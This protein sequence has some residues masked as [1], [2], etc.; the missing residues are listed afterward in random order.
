MLGVSKNRAQTISNK[1]DFPRPIAE[2]S[3]GRVW[4]TDAVVEFCQRTGRT[5]HPL[6][7]GAAD[8][9]EADEP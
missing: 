3:V 7:D 1:V 4:L 9:A 5:V 8:G 2:L 6:D